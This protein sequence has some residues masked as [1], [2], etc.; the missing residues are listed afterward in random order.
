MEDS[1]VLNLKT[2]GG[3]ITARVYIDASG[4]DALLRKHFREITSGCFFT[5]YSEVVGRELGD[6][7]CHVFQKDPNCAFWVFPKG[8]KTNIGGGFFREDD[9]DLKTEIGKLKKDLGLEGEVLDSGYAPLPSAKPID[10]VYRNTVAIGDAGVTVNPLTGGGIGPTLKAVTILADTLRKEREIF[11][12]SNE[13][14][15]KRSDPAIENITI[16]AELF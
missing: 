9:T 15:W 8:S 7:T 4:V 2:G 3:K 16:S 14:T 12:Y 6:G 1:K 5:G 11:Q 13:D 10:L